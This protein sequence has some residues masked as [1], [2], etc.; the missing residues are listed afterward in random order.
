VKLR[1]QPIDWLIA[2]CVML[3]VFSLNTAIAT[4]ETHTELC[5]KVKQGE[6]R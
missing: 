3:A 1:H 6:A 5:S 2:G 4:I